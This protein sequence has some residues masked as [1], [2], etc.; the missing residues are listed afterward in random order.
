MLLKNASG[1]LLTSCALYSPFHLE[2]GWGVGPSVIVIS[3]L[4]LG[5]KPPRRRTS[6][7]HFAS[8]AHPLSESPLRI[9]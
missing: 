7:L 6:A 9:I 8:P 1:L 4:N 3:I 5:A 2:G